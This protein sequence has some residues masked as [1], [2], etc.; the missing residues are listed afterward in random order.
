VCK[1]VK[2]SGGMSKEQIQNWRDVLV[3][4]FGIY[5]RIMPVSEIVAYKKKMEQEIDKLAKEVVPLL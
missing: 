4:T 1:K 3:A 5:A 2:E